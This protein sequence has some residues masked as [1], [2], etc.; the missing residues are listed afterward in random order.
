MAEFDLNLPTELASSISSSSKS[1]GLDKLIAE[2]L[3]AC[4]E[5]GAC[6][7]SAEYSSDIVGTTNTFGDAQLHVDVKADEYMFECLKESGV[8]SI[9]SSEENPTEVDLGGEGF[10]VAFDPLD[11]SSIIDANF[12]VG[13]IMGVW[14]G[15]GLLGRTGREQ[16]C[17]IIVMH[18]PRVTAAVAL[19]AAA[20]AN[21]LSFCTELTMHPISNVWATSVER[22]AIAPQGK[23]FAPGNLRATG[24]NP[25]YKEMVNYWIEN[26]YTLRYSGGLVPDVYHILIKGKG[27]FS[28]ASSKSC[29]AKLRLLYECAPIA[30]V[31][32]AAGGASCVCPTEAGEAL[33]PVSLLDIPV[34]DVDRRVGACYGSTQEVA[35]FKDVLFG[36]ATIAK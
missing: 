33:E 23:V 32:E 15:R 28:N 29:K 4:G 22:M 13:T 3:K 9:A 10:S 18:G 16:L 2:L 35:R 11:G 5:I 19:S 7:R 6:L 34:T 26:K 25:R 14:P 21:G 1:A 31:I 8:V 30:L 36:D 27:I 12:A 17:S 20:S 24:D